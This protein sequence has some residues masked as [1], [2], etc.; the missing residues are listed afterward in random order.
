MKVPYTVVRLAVFDEN[1]QMLGSPSRELIKICKESQEFTPAYH[2]PQEGKPSWLP[3]NRV[4][5]KVLSYRGI[6]VTRV[7]VDYVFQSPVAR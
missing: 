6:P 1:G 2:I 5:V 4:K 3:A 7:K